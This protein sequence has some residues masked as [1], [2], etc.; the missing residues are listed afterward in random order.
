M[1][2]RPPRRRLAAA[3]VAVLAL[4]A[5]LAVGY[6]PRAG[7]DAAAQTPA[8]PPPT[9]V[10]FAID[11]SGSMFGVAGEPAS[12]PD[13]QR[14]EGVRGLIEVLRG[15]LGAPGEQRRVELGALSFGG[16]E[17]EL[18]SAPA[19]VLDEA[20]SGRLRAEQ[21]GGGTDFR[22]ALC[23]AWAMAA[24]E[25]PPPGAGCPALPSGFA[26]T[27]GTADS[28]LLVVVITDGS[29]A[30]GGD[31][32]AFDGAPAS[33]DC[34]DGHGGYDSPD[35]EAYL[36][37]LAATWSALRAER[38]A[39][40]VVIGLDAPGQWFPDAE[41][42]WQH[43]AQCG[44]RSQRDCADRVVRSVDPGQLAALILGAFPGVDL[45]EAI[46]GD[47]FTCDVPGGLVSVGF[48]VTGLTAGARTTVENEDGETYSSSGDHRE[49]AVRG[50]AAHVWRFRRPVAGRWTVTGDGPPGQ[51][52]IVDFEPVEFR[53]NSW[54]WDD[55]ALRLGLTAFDDVATLRDQF[56]H[57]ELLREG[58][59]LAGREVQ[60]DHQGGRSYALTAPFELP[61][62]IAHRLVLY[63]K[64]PRTRLEV[65]RFELTE[66]LPTPSPTRTPPPAET[67]PPTETPSPTP[68]ATP[69][70]TP[71]PAPTPPCSTFSAEWD[72][73]PGVASRWRWAFRAGLD[74]PPVRFRDSAVWRVTVE[75]PDCDEAIAA[76]A[77]IL[78]CE[79]CEAEAEGTPPL[80]LDVSTR[81]RPDDA[82]EREASS[83]APSSGVEDSRR[84][85]VRLADS[86]LLYWEPVWAAALHLLALA[87]LAVGVSA[88]AVRRPHA[89]R[90]GEEPAPP[91]ALGVPNERRT[92]DGIVR[93]GLFVWRRA[94]RDEQAA[95]GEEDAPHA[96]LLT[97]RWLIF[98]PLVARDMRAGA[99]WRA[100]W[101][102]EPTAEASD[103]EERRL[104]IRRRAPAI[105]YRQPPGW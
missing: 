65:G 20:L 93:R 14:I 31:D 7:G 98:G 49:L 12:D 26:D 102:G 44:G 97:L 10:V 88:V 46:Q 57:V 5:L 39:D 79:W 96:P 8:A 100:R 62:H 18:L 24:G 80:P 54:Q 15:F 67:P 56:Y 61:A 27:T 53:M 3:L 23:A 47:T 59:V 48:Q 76:S 13:Q 21:V 25:T 103:A 92:L 32:L 22:S 30:R 38:A 69:T 4:A 34:P 29:P 43:V 28:R 35:G 78:G 73:E 16:D 2:E 66:P 41:T 36:C 11:N 40:L 83:Y 52:A 74:F 6:L 60:I 84:E 89:W 86:W 50:A 95:A 91:I 19:P 81:G 51:R 1:P 37:A 90:R 99:P 64:T 77:R 85:S 17:P 9:R 70:V 94:P 87:A 58:R 33:A 75:S 105:R 63:L 55:D 42:Y 68:S 71:T 101:L 104:D 45:C 82:T 72:G